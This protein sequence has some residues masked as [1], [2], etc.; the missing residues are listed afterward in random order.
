VIILVNR[1][2][3]TDS[4]TVL[5]M[6]A[7]GVLEAVTAFAFIVS[8]RAYVGPIIAGELTGDPVTVREGLHRS[9]TRTPALVG[10]IL[11]VVFLVM[12]IPFFVSLPLVVLVG[13]IPGNPVEMIGFPAAAAVGGVVFAVPFL[14]LLFKFWFAPEACVIGQYG[15][16]ESLRVSWRI[17][18]NYRRKFLLIVLIV[19]GS[20]P[21]FYLPTY[22][23][24]MGTSVASLNPVL[25]MISSS[26]GES[27]SIVWASAYAHIYVQGIVS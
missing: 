8:I 4:I 14:L 24:E 9:L 10:A 26:I 13:A 3:E 2:L 19:L 17:T 20:T 1:V 25:H 23:P 27:L 5:P 16:I 11:L 21:S 12:T 6:P 22:L 7:V 18:T 15:P